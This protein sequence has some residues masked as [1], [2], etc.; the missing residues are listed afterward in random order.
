MG[1]ATLNDFTKK[2]PYKN[3]LVGR[4]LRNDDIKKALGVKGSD[5]VEEDSWGGG[6]FETDVIDIHDRTLSSYIS[7]A[8][9]GPWEQTQWTVGFII[10]DGNRIPREVIDGN[11]IPIDFYR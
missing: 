2:A 7:E 1:L 8:F 9:G 4:L 10:E 3:S 6:D 11:S 5:L